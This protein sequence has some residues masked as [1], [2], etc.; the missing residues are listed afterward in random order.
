MITL[1]EAILLEDLFSDWEIDRNER[2]Q[3]I[4][5]IM[6]THYPIS[7]SDYRE[8]ILFDTEDLVALIFFGD[9]ND[10]EEVDVFSVPTDLFFA[11]EADL[12]ALVEVYCK[13]L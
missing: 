3:L 9:N 4:A 6:A 11:D 7:A 12:P 2:G 13:E 1:E 10:P 5:E 8:S